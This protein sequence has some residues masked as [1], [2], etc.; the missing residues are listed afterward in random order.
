MLLK[1]AIITLFGGGRF[2]FG[3][4]WYFRQWRGIKQ[5]GNITK[6]PDN[7]NDGGL[8]TS[9]DK[10]ITTDTIAQPNPPKLSPLPSMPKS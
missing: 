7:D 6:S 10:V 9:T 8:I 2:C 1:A 4:D 3:G 5:C